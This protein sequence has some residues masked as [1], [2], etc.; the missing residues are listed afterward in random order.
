MHRGHLHLLNNNESLI[1]KR[2]VFSIVFNSSFSQN[3]GNLLIIKCILE[4]DK[5][6]ESNNY[7]QRILTKDTSYK[8]LYVLD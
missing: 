1:N 2:I 4:T 3:E 5:K 6:I 7:I 8:K